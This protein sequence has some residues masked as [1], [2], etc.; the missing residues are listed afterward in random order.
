MAGR[1][2]GIFGAILKLR[3]GDLGAARES[4]ESGAEIAGRIGAAEQEGYAQVVLGQIA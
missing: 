3:D 1:T 4:A 2:A